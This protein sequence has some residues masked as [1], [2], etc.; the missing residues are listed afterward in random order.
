MKSHIP[1][2]QLGF[3]AAFVVI[4]AGLLIYQAYYI[5]PAQRCEAHGDWWDEKDKVCAVPVP[6]SMFTGRRVGGKLVLQPAP[7]PAA[8]PAS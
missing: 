7:H 1:K 6:I 8:K 2:V 3:V 5:W 4:F